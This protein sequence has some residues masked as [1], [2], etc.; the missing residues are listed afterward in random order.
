[1]AEFRQSLPNAA[2]RRMLLMENK[3]NWLQHMDSASSQC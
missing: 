2:R 3:K 1:M